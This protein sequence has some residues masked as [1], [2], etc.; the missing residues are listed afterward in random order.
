MG[1]CLPRVASYAVVAQAQAKASVRQQLHAVRVEYT[2]GPTA[3]EII[4]SFCCCWFSAVCVSR[5]ESCGG[6]SE[7]DTDVAIIART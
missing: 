3:F 7:L 6:D 1:A 5:S 4:R 2:D